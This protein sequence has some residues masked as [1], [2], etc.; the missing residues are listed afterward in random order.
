MSYF[1][2]ISN[3]QMN[4]EP[5]A[6]CTITRVQ[7]SVPR[8][9]GSKM[10]VYLDGRISGSVGGGEM[11]SRVIQEAL[12]ALENG[13]PRVLEYS[14]SNPGRGDPGVCGGTLEVFVD[15]IL[16]EASIIVIGQCAK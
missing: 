6:L 13:Q 8:R 15:P 4:G 3:A 7:G 5:V 14:L 2:Q 10:L 16:P 1:D 9:E 12:D 11:E